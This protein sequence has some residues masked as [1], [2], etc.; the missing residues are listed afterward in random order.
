M[1]CFSI[2]PLMR[3]WSYEVAQVRRVRGCSREEGRKWIK[4]NLEKEYHDHCPHQLRGIEEKFFVSWCLQSLY[5]LTPTY[6]ATDG[7]MKVFLCR[8]GSDFKRESHGDL[9]HW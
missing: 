7:T 8:L 3:G 9:S 1:V 6:F 5:N 2:H 4:N